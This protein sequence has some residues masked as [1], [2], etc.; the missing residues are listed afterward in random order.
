MGVKDLPKH[1]TL[2]EVGPRDGLQNERKVSTA[3]KIQLINDLSETGLTHIE[4]GSFVSP[5]W[6]PQMADSAKVLQRITRKP[7]ITYSALVPNLNGLESAI[8][9]DVKHIA[10]FTSA[11]ESFSR[12]NIN[13]SI[14]ESLKRFEP[15][16]KL[17]QQHNIKVRGYLSCITDCP[18]EGETS[19][20]Q[21]SHVAQSLYQLGCYEISLGDTL[22]MASPIRIAQVLEAIQ[23]DVPAECLA[24]HCHDTYG[25][26]LVNIYQALQCGINVVDCSV[27]GLG[28]CPYAPGANGN[29]ATEDVLYLCHGLGIKTG[30]DL[31]KVA[32]IGKD[33]S[34][35]LNRIPS[36]KVNLSLMLSA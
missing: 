9:A 36:S 23:T 13:C 31:E 1:V 7:G 5:K 17:A 32:T 19:I 33:I 14:K 10:I 22:G 34:Q 27:G 21:V 12:K 28:G 8:A 26:A 4:S 18:Y 20:T 24:I 16:M 6:V 2:V 11:S 3:T 29:V 15:I 30:V 25:Q 35:K